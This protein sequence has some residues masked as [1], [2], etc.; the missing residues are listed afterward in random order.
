MFCAPKDDDRPERMASPLVRW[1]ARSLLTSVRVTP[2]A[3]SRTFFA[4][5]AM[6]TRSGRSSRF[7]HLE[8]MTTT[9]PRRVT[10]TWSMSPLSRVMPSTQPQMS[11]RRRAVSSSIVVFS[12]PQAPRRC[13]MASRLWARNAEFQKCIPMAIAT[14]CVTPRTYHVN[15]LLPHRTTSTAV[16][17]T[18]APTDDRERPRDQTAP[19]DEPCSTQRFELASRV[20]LMLG[21]EPLQI[22]GGHSMRESRVR[23]ENRWICGTCVAHQSRNAHNRREPLSNVCAGQTAFR[24]LVGMPQARLLIRWS[25]VRARQGL[26]ARFRRSGRLLRPD[27]RKPDGAL[28]PRDTEM[29]Q[30]DQQ[31]PTCNSK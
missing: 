14:T 30:Q 1:R 16:T 18:S 21:H 9:P 23:L 10:T 29:A 24:P 8:S 4:A 5:A 12:S 26:P 13:L 25:S 11:R 20:R 19:L 6:S 31:E 17:T 27:L 3:R 22:G 7:R 2:S 28:S 15:R